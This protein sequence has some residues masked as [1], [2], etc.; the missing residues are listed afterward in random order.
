MG[1]E[2]HNAFIQLESL[3]SIDDP[4]ERYIEGVPKIMV[5]PEE[6]DSPCKSKSKTSI[7]DNLSSTRALERQRTG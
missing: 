4:I 1:M 2:M 7:F 6:G 5:Q 3:H